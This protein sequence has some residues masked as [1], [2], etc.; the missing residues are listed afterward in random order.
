ML[1]NT[2]F[3]E[4][5]ADYALTAE[6][7]EMAVL[8]H[9]KVILAAEK[10]GFP[11]TRILPLQL[12][13]KEQSTFHTSQRYGY[14]TSNEKDERLSYVWRRYCHAMRQPFV[15]VIYDDIPPCAV[16]G[17]DMSTTRGR[18]LT[19]EGMR[20]IGA[21]FRTCRWGQ[22]HQAQV[23]GANIGPLFCEDRYIFCEEAKELV[24]TVYQ[25]ACDKV[26]FDR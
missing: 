20:T 2:L 9:L 16:V 19:D 5:R 18:V 26:V 21:L 13:R 15:Y 6:E 23:Y 24:Q 4:G 11:R 25:V 7:V 17:V 14:L 12:T 8:G 10:Y 3:I 1:I 22:S